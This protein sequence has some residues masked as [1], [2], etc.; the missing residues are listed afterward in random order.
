[1]QSPTVGPLCALPPAEAGAAIIM[2]A[3]NPSNTVLLVIG[4]SLQPTPDEKCFF[5]QHVACLPRRIAQAAQKTGQAEVSVG[6]APLRLPFLDLHDVVDAPV[7]EAG[8]FAPRLAV[9]VEP[10]QQR[11]RVN[12]AE[13]RPLGVMV[14]V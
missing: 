12:A 14:E 11:R 8:G 13:H 3:A 1:M 10:R 7:E 5:R 6:A 9:V 2:A 4:C